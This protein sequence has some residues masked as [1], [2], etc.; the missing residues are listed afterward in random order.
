M[1]FQSAV[2]AGGQYRLRV[3]SPGSKDPVRVVDWFN[4]MILNSAKNTI[5][6]GFP[7]N[8]N[9]RI[10]V[11]ISDYPVTSDQVGVINPLQTIFMSEV[12]DYS[13]SL[14]LQLTNPED[15]HIR[16]TGSSTFTLQLKE[17]GTINELGIYGFSRAL[18]LD[19]HSGLGGVSVA[20]DDIVEI[21]Y[22]FTLIYK[23][24]KYSPLDIVGNAVFVNVDGDLQ[25]GQYEL[26]SRPMTYLPYNMN[27]KW[28]ELLKTQLTGFVIGVPLADTVLEIDQAYAVSETESIPDDEGKRTTFSFTLPETSDTLVYGIYLGNKAFGGYYYFADPLTDTPLGIR[29]TK[30]NTISFDLHLNW[31]G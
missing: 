5:L 23:F 10:E 9:K 8:E 17:A 3:Y 29:V 31:A 30:A 27:H 26:R 12:V 4:N 6:D 24:N 21:D 19:K 22:R 1:A 7:E 16:V 11:G 25:T 28:D 2:Q 18:V 13:D 20:V 14:S 15:M